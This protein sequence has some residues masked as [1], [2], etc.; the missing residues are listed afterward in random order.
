MFGI[1][2]GLKR[3]GRIARLTIFIL[4]ALELGLTVGVL[5]LFAITEESAYKP[6]LW[7]DGFDN[8]FNSSPAQPIYNMVNGK[9]S[10]TPLVWSQ[11]LV[12]FN[13]TI[14][15]L[16]TFTL[17]VK[18]VMA[19]MRVLYP[20]ISIIIHGIE[21]GL[22][23]FSIHGQTSPDTI[24]PQHI[25]NGP[26]WFITKSCSVTALPQNIGYCKQ[27]KA[28]FYVSVVM[29]AI[30][31]THLLLSI[32]AILFASEEK[33]DDQEALVEKK[34]KTRQEP[35]WEMVPIPETPK[36]PYHNMPMSPMT[37]R[38]KAFQSLQGVGPSTHQY[39]FPPPPKKA[40]K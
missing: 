9:K 16:S 33:D 13:I 10:N 6:K 7:Q 26:P 38:T 5:A 40:K 14:S 1:R 20:F 35:L 19:I 23:M 29:A 18:S 4:L 15:V 32:Y 12:Q 24:D 39:A 30:F 34:G 11:Y 17:L 3:W 31:G 8:G 21:F 28:S 36:T 25:N 22:Y 37:P 27:A 2:F